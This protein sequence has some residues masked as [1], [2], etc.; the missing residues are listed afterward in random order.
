VSAR[1]APQR[2]RGGFAL[3]VVLLVL[4]ALLVLAAPF[5]L[6]ARNADR[7]S[8]ELEDRAEARLGLDVAG[9]HARFLLGE[10]HPGV[11]R[12]P[13][14]DSLEEVAVDNRFDPDF[15]DPNDESG[16]M[17][18]LERIDV[19]AQ[20]DLN[21]APPQMFANLMG[22]STRLSRAIKADE[23][24]IPLGSTMGFD[25]AG[26][27]WVGG[28]LLRYEKIAEGAL[29]EPLRGVLGPAN[30]SDWRGG[31]LPPS[32]HDAG[33]PVID[34]RAFA[35]ALWRIATGDG[36]LR[37]FDARERVREVGAFVIAAAARMTA[38]PDPSG[39]PGRGVDAEAAAKTALGEDVLRPLLLHGSVHGGVR[40]GQAWQRPTRL[41][42][43]IRGGRDGILTVQDPRW[44]NPGSTVRITD[45]ESTELA[46]VQEVRGS[47]EVVLDRIL[48]ND[49]PAHRAVLRVLARRPVNLNTAAPEVLT[50]LFANLQVSGRNSRIT[51]DEAAKL[52]TLVAESRP[53]EGFED[54]LRRVVLPAAGLE[55]LPGDAPVVPA[56]LAGLPGGSGF[57]DPDDAM[58]LYMNGLNANDSGLRYSTMPYAFVS[59]DTYDLELRATVGAPSGVERVAM[60]REETDLVVPQRQLLA[61]WARQ[62]DFEAELRLDREAPWWMTGPNATSRHDSGSVPPSRLWAEL[63]TAQ[64]QPFL[65]GVTD[66]SAFADGESPPTAEHVFPSREETGWIRLWPSRV[67][68]SRPTDGRVIH[69]DHET[70]DP[71]GRFLPDQ[72]VARAADDKQ[73]AWT[74]PNAPLC[75]PLTFSMWTKPRAIADSLLLD[76]GGTSRDS[77][78]V[79][80]ALDGPDLVLRVVAA[81]GDHPDTTEKEFA[82]ARFAVARGTSPGLPID[83]WSH[84]EV[85][86]RG[87]RPD[88]IGMLVNG[89]AHGVRTPG[90]TRLTGSIGQ[91]DPV[92]PVESTE[93][94]PA[95]CTV[96]IGNELVEVEVAGGSMNAVRRETGAAAGCG[97]RI[98][99]EKYASQTHD[100]TDLPA[101]LAQIATAHPAGTTVQ[102]A[103]YSLPLETDIPAGQGTLPAAIGPFRVGRVIGVTRADGSTYQGDAISFAGTISSYTA[104]HGMDGIPQ[105]QAG[106]LILECADDPQVPEEQ[107]M[108]AFSTTGGYAMVVQTVWADD[109]GD[110]ETDT[111]TQFGGIEIIRYGGYEGRTLLI[112]A[113][114]VDAELPNLRGFAGEDAWMIGGR[115]AFIAEYAGH[116]QAN[117]ADLHMS[118]RCYVVPI[119]LGVSSAESLRTSDPSATEEESRLLQITHLQDAELTEWVRYDYQD[120]AG[121]FVR[122]DP[123]TLIDV[124]NRIASPITIPPPTGGGTGG[125][126]TGGTGGT[127]GGGTAGAGGTGDG[128]TG[129]GGAL[130]AS[131]ARPPTQNQQTGGSAWLPTI[132]ENENED[133]TQP[134]PFSSCVSD[135]L[136]FRGVLGTSSHAHAIGTPVHPVFNVEL[137]GADSGRPGRLDAAFLFGPNFDHLGWPVRVHRAHVPADTVGV[138]LWN[139]PD[140]QALVAGSAGEDVIPNDNFLEHSFF[141]ALQDRSPESIRPGSVD[142]TGQANVVDTRG[143]ARLSCFPSGERPRIVGT[144]AVGGGFDGA[145][146]GAVPSAVVDEIVFGNTGF[147]LHT[148]LADPESMAGAALV[149]QADASDAELQMRVL[150]QTVRIA[151]GDVSASYAFLDETPQDAGLLRIGGE[152]VCYDQRD[153]STGVLNIA[154][155]G[156]G[157]LG[158]RAQFHQ[159][160][161]P[162]SFLEH[163]AVSFLAGSLNAGDASIPVASVEDFPAQ[164]T[165]LIGSE[166]LHYTRI[167]GNVLEMPRASD[168]PGRMDEK[169]DGLFRGRYGTAAA[170]HVQGEPVI[171]FPFR[172]WDRWQSR[173]DAPELSY[174]GL[175]IDQPSAY[176]DACFFEKEDAEA[177]QIG[178]L[179]RVEPDAPWDADPESDPRLRLHWQGDLEGRPIPIRRQ[180]DRIDWRVFVKYAP[181]AFDPSTG[182]AHGWKQTPVLKKFGA[183]Y[184]GPPICLSSVVR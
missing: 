159:T 75:R 3:L 47:G 27:V 90:L 63:G 60:V 6:M 16:L 84:V 151:I 136:Q 71:E 165:V 34:Q 44:V 53:F 160:T 171:L 49:Y 92:I 139:Q 35:P 20:V 50:A 168:Q 19:A 80:I 134:F 107:Y 18:D 108:S 52:A 112:A 109:P 93:G 175:S 2:E 130:F 148:P 13:Y 115:R 120:S 101:N 141:V 33:A 155:G 73:V 65:P 135:E 89:L 22:L 1:Q 163:R 38:V 45:G 32:A 166:L 129:G 37:P 118:W 154:P 88:Q 177:C 173:A 95:R 150:P 54:F 87:T 31:P 178:V 99:R 128:G 152:I 124:Y 40:G 36:E 46:L 17:W 103:G 70:R 170:P 64:G 153:T 86:V 104:G 96:R 110:N 149:L 181:G 143:M 15:L 76:L 42:S 83:V 114:G 72:T 57:I 24:E 29:V 182:L 39:T 131:V 67:G 157:L 132:G 79:S 156:R 138:R 85:D 140:P 174:F 162:A 30:P 59:R 21:S 111:G 74:A 144:L 137:G 97:G 7:S 55:K 119:S 5:L 145:Q 113:R 102:L 62:E 176:W 77:D 164:G 43:A 41:T 125:G 127:G 158:T 161:E 146:G 81:G 51:R 23:K 180:S 106:G 48:Q 10:S 121:Q 69:F 14:F 58:A 56:I 100:A 116:Y 25:P 147:P 183:F 8:V 126:G 167:S 11:D 142:P 26:I 117:G 82:E 12:S 122:D 179:E 9:R 98:A 66:M 68:W 4:I 123:R 61:L 169:G 133:R 91:N 28:E 172:Y 184:Y 94:F 78:R 105:S